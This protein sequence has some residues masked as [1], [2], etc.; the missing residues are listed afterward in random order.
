MTT[1]A[2]SAHESQSS[3]GYYIFRIDDTIF[4]GVITFPSRDE[5]KQT[6][7][8]G[9]CITML[10]NKISAV[11]LPCGIPIYQLPDDDERR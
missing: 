10:I 5:D 4:V 7:M 6:Y 11:T 8:L 2:K 9:V 1:I 3:T